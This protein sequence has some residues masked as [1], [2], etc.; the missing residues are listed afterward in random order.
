MGGIFSTKEVCFLE[1]QLNQ[2]LL[3]IKKSRQYA[4]EFVDPRLRD[5]CNKISVKHAQH[6]YTLLHHLN[7][8]Q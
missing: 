1:K 7:Q 3:M 6:Y 4:D 5:L 2:E 8:I